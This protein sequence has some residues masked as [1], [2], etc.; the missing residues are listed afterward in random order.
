MLG[1]GSSL[2]NTQSKWYG[3][4]CMVWPR[5][6]YGALTPKPINRNIKME[7]YVFSMVQNMYTFFTLLPPPFYDSGDVRKAISFVILWKKLKERRR[8]NTRVEWFEDK[9]AG[10]F[11]WSKKLLI[12]KALHLP[13]NSLFPRKFL[14]WRHGPDWKQV[15][16][17]M[18]LATPLPPK[19]VYL[20]IF[21]FIL[22]LP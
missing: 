2:Q 12:S 13:G 4:R 5:L 6:F 15:F 18:L 11:R 14:L 8:K 21:D 17:T 1:I 7:A 3:L 10:I 19:T 16:S 22:L 9:I 20:N